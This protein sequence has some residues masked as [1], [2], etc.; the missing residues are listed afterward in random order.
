[1]RRLRYDAVSY[2]LTNG[3]AFHRLKL[4]NVIGREYEYRPLVDELMSFQNE[5]G[6]WPWQL[7][8]GNPSGVS[9]TAKILEL[10]PSVSVDPASEP[11]SRA[12][13]YLLRL[14]NRDGGWS[15]SPELD[16]IVPEDW[17]WVSTRDSGYQTADAVNA[18][19]EIGHLG[20]EIGRAIEFL[21]GMQN[22]EGGWPSHVGPDSS[23]DPA[24]TDHIIMAFLRSGEPR[25]SPVIVM[26]ERML[27]EKRRG[28]DSPVDATAVLSVLLAL[29]YPPEEEHVSELIGW[30]VDAQRPDG[31]WNWF[32]DLPSNPS[33][34]VDC[35]EQLVR[36][37]RLKRS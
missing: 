2:V 10:L 31:G 32:G 7:A 6:G 34:T 13:S 22:E 20:D 26:A 33:Q 18:L 19:L 28:W 24:T 35:L 25:G 27:L 3:N 30:L 29:G 21:R 23:T 14:Q 9:D 37:V 17:T 1:M 5:D 36:F 8:V 4:A 15:E 16:R 12:V 11:I